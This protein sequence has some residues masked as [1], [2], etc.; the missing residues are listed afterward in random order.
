VYTPKDLLIILITFWFFFFEL[1]AQL[2]DQLYFLVLVIFVFEAFSHIICIFFGEGICQFY[3]HLL[4]F[5]YPM[6]VLT[7]STRFYVF[8]FQ[9]RLD[10]HLNTIFSVENLILNK[11]FSSFLPFIFDDLGV[12]MLTKSTNNSKVFLLLLYFFLI[13]PFAFKRFITK[14][15]QLYEQFF[16]LSCFLLII[17]Y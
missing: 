9:L 11:Y 13:F 6:W 5:I 1:E 3:G 10:L 8:V 12:L 14:V 7:K 4:V 16:D 2:S 17:L 15:I